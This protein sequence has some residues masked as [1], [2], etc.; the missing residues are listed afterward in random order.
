M[1]TDM[2]VS[3]AVESNRE[4]FLNNADM[5]IDDREA[6]SD[7]IFIPFEK[8]RAETVKPDLGLKEKIK[9]FFIS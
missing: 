7:E 6:Y 9:R 3:V 2:G 8:D 4:E 1:L 5:S